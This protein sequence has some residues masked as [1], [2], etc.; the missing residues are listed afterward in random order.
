MNVTVAVQTGRFTRRERLPNFAG[1]PAITSRR[2]PYPFCE[3]CRAEFRRTQG[4]EF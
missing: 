2:F 4:Y 1:V 3:L